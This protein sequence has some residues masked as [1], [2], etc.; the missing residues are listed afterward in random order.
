VVAMLREKG[1][2]GSAAN[3]TMAMALQI[4]GGEDDDEA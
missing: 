1:G 4:D 2:D 3:S